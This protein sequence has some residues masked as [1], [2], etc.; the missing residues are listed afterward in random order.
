V[1]TAIPYALYAYGVALFLLVAMP[2]GRWLWAILLLA[3]PLRLFSVGFR[4]AIGSDVET[5][6]QLLTQ[7]EMSLINTLE[8]FW[9]IACLP[10]S[11]LAD[12]LPFPFLWVGICD[13]ILFVIMARV[14]GL[15]VAALHDLVYLPSTGMG[16]IRQALA[17]KLLMIAVVY[18]VVN[19]RRS[20]SNLILA[21]PLVHL[22]S[23]VPAAAI[24][25]QQSRLITKLILGGLMAMALSVLVDEA[26]I[27]KV[28]F[29]MEFEGFRTASDIYASWLK[30]AFVLVGAGLFTSALLFYW[31]LY[32]IALVFAVLEFY[33]P[34]IAV[35][36]G[37]YFEQ[38]EVMLVGGPMRDS[39]RRFAGFWYALV[40]LA[41]TAR[42]VL[43]VDGLPK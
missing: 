3:L 33:V 32:A 5:Y 16:A 11:A 28:L 2:Q 1:D 36:I 41:Y 21:S 34:E 4:T 31:G 39:L 20:I 24:K 15:R 17:M 30:R 10:S 29:Y 8:A 35:R 40:A 25:L 22:A 6:T 9:N 13:C 19:N 7:C 12:V 38:F 43:N 14:C 27:S 23:I 26:L 37:A 18:Q 42:Y